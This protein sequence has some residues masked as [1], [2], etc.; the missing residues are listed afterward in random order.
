VNLTLSDRMKATI[1]TVVSLAASGRTNDVLDT[2]AQHAAQA[3]R[4]AGVEGAL[5]AERDRHLRERAL[6][7]LVGGRQAGVTY[8]YGKRGD[9]PGAGDDCLQSSAGTGYR[10]HG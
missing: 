8:G 6:A 4:R 7:N 10:K 1:G 2:L 3:V 9:V 5:R